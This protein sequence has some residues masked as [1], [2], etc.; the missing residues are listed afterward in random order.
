MIAQISFEDIC[1]KVCDA[2]KEADGS[3]TFECPVCLAE[4]HPAKRVRLFLNGS[5][6][7]LRYA[8]SDQ[9]TNREHIKPIK[10]LLGLNAGQSGFI[11]E[12]LFNG[13]LTLEI[14]PADRGKQLIV[15]RNCNS[16]FHRDEIY[17][18]RA[19][20]REKFVAALDDFA[21]DERKQIAHSLLEMA[22]RYI[23]VRNAVE[24]EKEAVIEKLSFVVCDDGRIAETTMN[25]YVVYDPR[26]QITDYLPRIEFEG[27]IYT[28]PIQE[29]QSAG[30]GLPSGYEEYNTIRNL[31][32]P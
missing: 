4:G 27:V 24:Q 22:D 30:I 13:R 11:R 6:S 3:I 31:M 26:E 15:A 25:G 12:T 21:S 1:Q 23:I 2:R 29:L 19:A 17:L 32:Q 7:C 10:D 28:P 14:S 9:D 8:G 18:N 5:I 16:V 20:E